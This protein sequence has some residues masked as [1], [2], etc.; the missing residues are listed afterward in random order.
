MGGR[1]LARLLARHDVE[2]VAVADPDRAALAAASRL[3]EDLSGPGRRPRSFADGQQMMAAVDLAAVVIA[4]P[5]NCHA[6]HVLSA[7]KSG[8]S[9][10]VEKPLAASVDECR[11]VVASASASAA[12]GGASRPIV[13]VGHIE[14]FNPAVIAMFA[15]VRSGLVGQVVQIRAVRRGP[16]PDRRTEIGAAL[17]VAVHDVDLI[18]E[19]VGAMPVSVTATVAPARAQSAAESSIRASLVFADGARA[20]VAAGWS[21]SERRRGIEVIGESGKLE[22]DCLSQTLSHTPSSGEPEQLE[23]SVA[24][25]LVQQHDAFVDAVQHGRPSPVPALDGLRAVQVVTC[26]LR[27]AR[28]GRSAAVG[29]L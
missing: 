3:L 8:T 11:A 19:L 28:S 14:R 4:T 27:A 12:A 23:V 16:R 10:L 13:Q 26:M 2:V 1:H 29:H 22:V 5:G 21:A 15:A 24:E 18:C 20:S 7:L 17:D 9:V 6:Q 25:S